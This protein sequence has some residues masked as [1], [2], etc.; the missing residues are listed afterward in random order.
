MV[1]LY[2]EKITATSGLIFALANQ[3]NWK[4]W[5]ESILN[6]LMTTMNYN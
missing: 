2:W 3:A 6:M 5:L 4:F 1:L